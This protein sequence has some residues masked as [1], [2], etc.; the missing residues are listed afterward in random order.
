MNKTCYLPAEQIFYPGW[1]MVSQLRS[2]Q[3]V[4]DG[5]ALYAVPVSW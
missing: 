5:K 3:P 4:E 1:L 2:G